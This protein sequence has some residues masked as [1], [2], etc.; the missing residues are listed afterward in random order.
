M[1]REDEA[2]AFHYAVYD[3]VQS[4]PYG[5]VTSYGHIAKLV[6]KPRNSRHVGQALKSLPSEGVVKD[7]PYSQE[8]VPWWRVISS[9]GVISVRDRDAMQR[10]AA[11]LRRE[12]VEVGEGNYKISL[13]D[14]GW[15]PETE[16][17]DY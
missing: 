6:Y 10:Q 4:I 5:K 15:F 17:D 1:S 8:N 9:A 7:Y 13:V 2:R 12:G 3:M 14:Y 11:M 16:F